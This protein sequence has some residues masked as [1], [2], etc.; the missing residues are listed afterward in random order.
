VTTRLIIETEGKGRSFSALVLARVYAPCVWDAGIRE[1]DRHR[2]ALML[3]ATMPEEATAFAANL[4]EG[5]KMKLH[6][7]GFG[8]KGEPC[9]V[10]RSERFAIAPQRTA[11]GTLLLV[12]HPGL[13][14]FS[15]GMVGE[16]VRFVCLPPRA[17]VAQEAARFDLAA[18]RAH[19]DRCGFE[20]WS[21]EEERRQSWDSSRRKTRLVHGIADPLFPAFAA[22]LVAGVA[23]RV[24]FPILDEPLFW[25]QVAAAL[26]ADGLAVRS[27]ERCW[28]PERAPYA[29]VG[30][31]DSG[32]YPGAAVYASQAAIGAVLARETA[33][34]LKR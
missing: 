4:R 2:P 30:V 11:E 24:S 21:E 31:T 22:L 5:R 1:A 9:E 12:R 19:L 29:E 20:P 34:F 14:V 28:D 3:L 18:A 27:P 15:P 7:P 26:L 25:A 13:F 17:R 10:L 16:A 23:Q 8:Q 6:G 33:V 32:F